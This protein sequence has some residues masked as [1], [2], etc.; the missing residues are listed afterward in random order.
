MLKEFLLER[1]PSRICL[2]VVG[3]CIINTLLI[4]RLELWKVRWQLVLALAHVFQDHQ[5]TLVCLRVRLGHLLLEGHQE[6]S[7]LLAPLGEYLLL[8]F[9]LNFSLLLLLFLN[10]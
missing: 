2:F 10:S 3:T 1:V 7:P 8:S 4:Y 6:L 5:L 9:A